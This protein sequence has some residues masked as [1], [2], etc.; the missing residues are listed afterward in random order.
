MVLLNRIDNIELSEAEF[1]L[2]KHIVYEKAGITLSDTK[3]VLMFNRLHG[4]LAKLKLKS[5][6]QYY[7]YLTKG[8]DQNGIELKNFLEAITT[9]ETYFFRSS[10]QFDFLASTVIP[11]LVE[12]KE[13]EGDKRL[14]FWSS[15]C[16]TGEEAYSIA[17]AVIE[18]VP[19]P[20]QWTIDIFASDINSS[21]LKI[22]MSGVYEADCIREV[23]DTIVS[24]YF[25]RDKKDDRYRIKDFLRAMVKFSTHNLKDIFN[26]SNLDTIFCR[27]VM[28]YFDD[29]S[30]EKVLNNLS[31]VLAYNGYLFLG[32]SESLIGNNNLFEYVM[33]SVYIKQEHL[34]PKAKV[35][36]F[37]FL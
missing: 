21:V 27:N 3:R 18:S 13:A 11:R 2:L 17:I 5:F 32:Q 4:R 30:K 36:T 15:A 19:N 9:N 14:R 31:H 8:G 35:E 20:K 25:Q 28:I 6:K 10:K 26:H 37:L 22:A 7:D 34:I 1:K 29:A 16:S 12:R 33:P 24:K 23:K